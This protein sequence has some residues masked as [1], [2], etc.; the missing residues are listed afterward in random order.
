MSTKIQAIR[1]MEDVLPDANPLWERFQ[2]ACRTI[3][4]QYG[5]RNIHRRR[6]YGALRA[7]HR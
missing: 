3:F 1:G 7:R 2:D 5:Y 4:R 6:A